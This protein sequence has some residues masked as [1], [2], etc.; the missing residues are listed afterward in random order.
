MSWPTYFCFRALDPVL[1]VLVS[2]IRF[3]KKS[4]FEAGYAD[5]IR[6][7]PI[8]NP[9]IRVKYSFVVLGDLGQNTPCVCFDLLMLTGQKLFLFLFLIETLGIIHD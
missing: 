7:W 9:S 4:D 2:G 5:R 6:I 8:F 1:D 3:K